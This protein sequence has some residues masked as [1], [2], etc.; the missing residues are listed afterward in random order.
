MIRPYLYLFLLSLLLSCSRREQ[1]NIICYDLK[2][3]D[4]VEKINAKGTIQAVNTLTIVAPNVNY[5][6]ITVRHLVED[7]TYVKKGDTICI[8]DAPEIIN[9]FEANTTSLEITMA[10]LKKLEAE[11]AMKM[12]LLQAQIENNEADV[13][14]NSL[15]SIQQKFAPPVKQKLF[16][17]ELEKADVEKTKLQKKYA[18]RKKIE[19]AELRSMKSRI[20]QSENRINGIK[21][22]INS[23]TIVAPGD[24]IVMHTESPEIIFFDGT[25]AGSA[26]GKIEEN[27][28]VWSN[29]ALLQMPDMSQMQLSV[30]VPESDYKRIDTGQHVFISVDAVKN[31][32]TT[33]KIKKKTLVGQQEDNQSSVKT[34]E[35]IVSIDSCHSL[36][37]PGLSA[38]CKIII[39]EVKDTVVVPTLAIFEQDSTKIIYVARE[40]KFVIVPVETGLSN[41]SETIISKGLTS[42]ET[43]ALVE[44]PHQLIVRKGK[45]IKNSKNASDSIKTDTLIKQ[46]P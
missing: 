18:A 7:G 36:M 32:K 16:A 17:L 25:A 2:R 38:G 42:V 19:E 4:F 44:P 24:G 31:L 37:K 10:D 30:E 35:V 15:D 8:L 22:Q 14:L 23:L 45:T 41:S 9:D 20:T 40:G 6:S 27:S 43:I 29:M 12:S 34:Y 1:T 33:G 13:A 46:N 26:G 5:S 11:N 28:S 39:N 21:D 3:I